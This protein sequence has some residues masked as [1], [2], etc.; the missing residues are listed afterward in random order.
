M[1]T[2]SPRNESA[3]RN[4]KITKFALAGVAVLGVGAA[5]TSAAWTDNVLFGGT[6]TSGSIDLE[7]RVAGSPTWSPGPITIAPATFSD[8]APLEPKT[9]TLEVRNSGDGTLDLQPAAVQDQ[10]GPFFTGA[11]TDDVAIT[12]GGYTDAS[13]APGESAAFVVTLTPPDWANAS[14]NVTGNSF[15]VNV[16]A[17]T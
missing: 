10:L 13:L 4:R 9:V 12:F 3:D 15:T 1:A 7:G 8:L 11:T 6:A 14:Q 5:L 16:Q 2:K 17:T